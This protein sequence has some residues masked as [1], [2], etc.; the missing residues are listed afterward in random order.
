[1]RE[2]ISFPVIIV[3]IILAGLATACASSEN[4]TASA[5][6]DNYG[7]T[8]EV[9]VD[10]PSLTLVGYL[11]RVPGV[12]VTGNG[13]SANI[14]IRGTETLTLTSDPLFV[15][16]GVKIGR[17]FARVSSMVDMT[18][19]QKIRVL[20]GIEASVSYGSEGGNGVIEI[21]TDGQV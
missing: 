16:N 3:F 2:V 15:I 13:P 10:N 21:V 18:Q 6:D 4:G 1:M 20:R 12:R 8:T 5:P 14:V 9:Q 17:D 7:G 19:V 11:R